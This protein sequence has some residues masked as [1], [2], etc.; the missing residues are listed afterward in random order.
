MKQRLYHE[1]LYNFSDTSLRSLLLFV[2]WCMAVILAGVA[3]FTLIFML[4][5]SIP[6]NAQ[7]G[8]LQTDPACYDP[9]NVGRVGAPEWQGCASMFIADTAMM[10]RAGSWSAGGTET[11][12]LVGQYGVPYT[13]I[14][15]GLNVFTGQVTDMSDLFS[16][17]DFQGDIGYWDTSSVTSMAFMF[18]GADKFNQDIN[19]WDTAVVTT[20]QGMFM[21]A[22]RFNQ[23]LAAWD[24][25]QVT[26]MGAMFT[27]ARAFN[28]PI[29]SWDTA[30]VTDMNSMFRDA[31][32]FNQGL[33]GWD[34]SNVTDMTNMFWGA[35]AFELRA[36]VWCAI[37]MDPDPTTSGRGFTITI[38]PQVIRGPCP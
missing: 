29:G 11:F 30:R 15:T 3:V 34:M 8:P 13:F 21:G 2:L 25:S 24:T 26:N 1:F 6:A 10:R 17:T 16:N 4:M 18:A 37:A 27:L 36:D 22:T 12:Y 31:S 5:F 28:Q 33:D 9:A 23:P 7:G 14:D 38:N 19:G 20:M 32:A 35:D